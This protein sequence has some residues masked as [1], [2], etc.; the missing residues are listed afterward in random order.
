[1]QGELGQLKPLPLHLGEQL[2]SKQNNS[3]HPSVRPNFVRAFRSTMRFRQDAS[4]TR[5]RE[6]LQPQS[7]TLRT[8]DTGKAFP[9]TRVSTADASSRD[10]P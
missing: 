2:E 3:N 10:M 4:D 6:E 5:A 9:R 7:R 8:D 1:M